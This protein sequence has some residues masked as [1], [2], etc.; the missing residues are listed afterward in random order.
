MYVRCTICRIH[1][2]TVNTY[3]HDT[4]IPF[5]SQLS[6]RFD[7]CSRPEEDLPDSQIRLASRILLPKSHLQQ[8]DFKKVPRIGVPAEAGRGIWGTL[9]TTDSKLEKT[10]Y[11]CVI[12]LN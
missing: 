6:C 3:P 4:D 5:H 7:R 12:S 9:N 8:Y 1:R 10:F 11:A 2:T